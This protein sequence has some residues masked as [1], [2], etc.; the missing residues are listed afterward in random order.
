MGYSSVVS[1]MGAWAGLANLCYAELGLLCMYLPYLT[2]ADK[3]VQ[4]TDDL[5]GQGLI[6]PVENVADDRYVRSF[7]QPITSG[8]H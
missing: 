2:N 3:L 7:N 5:A 8:Q 6:D 1:G 4:D